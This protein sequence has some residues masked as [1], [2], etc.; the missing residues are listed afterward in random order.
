MNSRA[1][2]VAALFLLAGCGGGGGGGVAPITTPPGPGH[3]ALQQATLKISFPVNPGTA[4]SA[5]SPQY[6]SPNSNSIKITVNTV[7]AAA[8]E[9]WVTPNPFVATLTTTGGSPNCTVAGGTETCTVANVPAP[10]G[11]VNYTFGVYAS[12]DGSGTA[13]ATATVNE[14][15]VQGTLNTFTVTL[16]GVATTLATNVTTTA[17]TANSPLT[18]NDIVQVKDPSGAR[19][20][21]TA[22]FDNGA[23]V[24]VTNNDTSGQT[25]LVAGTG[26]GS[27]T[28]CVGNT[29]TLSHGADTVNLVYTGRAVAGSG[30]PPPVDSF[31]VTASSSG[32]TTATA[33]LTITDLPITFDVTTL[34]DAAHGGQAGDPNFNQL[35]LFFAATGNSAGF[36]AS[37]L[38][39]SN[40]P[41]SQSFTTST[42]CGSGG[43]AIATYTP[44]TGTSFTVTSQNPGICKITVSD[45]VGQSKDLW[46]SVTTSNFNVN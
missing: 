45:G 43:S 42:T 29:C 25:S 22:P 9:S 41:Y 18:Q 15:V 12:T 26:G 13:L 40:A 32:L 7:N 21:G 24:T 4:S 36:T 20:V 5:R 16:D 44:S 19:I 11:T 46:I 28:S 35:T 30:G 2:A 6:V 1:L 31:T 17:L 10:P 39:W 37:E 14:T 38:G 23:T 27:A 33:N 34:D 8:P 3:P